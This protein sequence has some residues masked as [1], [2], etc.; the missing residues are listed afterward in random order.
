VELTAKLGGAGCLWGNGATNRT[1]RVNASGIYTVTVTNLAGC[2]STSAP[3][4]VS[5]EP[6]SLGGAAQAESSTI[7]GGNETAIQLSGQ[8]GVV[9]LWQLSSDGRSWADI[10]SSEGLASLP[11][12]ILWKETLYRAVVQSGACASVASTIA[13]VSVISP[14]AILE[15]PQSAEV[16]PEDSV[17]FTVKAEGEGLIYQWRR[18]NLILPGATKSSY[19]IRV[20]S[21]A[22]AG[23]YMVVIRNAC[24]EWVSSSP[25]FLTVSSEP[26]VIILADDVVCPGTTG[27][28]ASIPDEG[29]D[30]VYTWMIDGGIIL[31]G[32]RSPS[33]LYEV[34]DSGPVELFVTVQ[35]APGCER[36]S[37][38]LVKV[39]SEDLTFSISDV[40]V[41]EGDIGM[42]E[43]VLMVTLSAPADCVVSVRWATEDG[44]ARADED[45]FPAFGMLVFDPGE[46]TKPVEIQVIG[47]LI[48][49]LDEHF[50]V[51]LS[52][53][54]NARILKERG[55]VTI[56]DDDPMPQ[57]SIEDIALVEGDSGTTEA[58]LVITLS[59]PS[60]EEVSV[61]IFTEDGSAVAW[62]DYIPIIGREVDPDSVP[63]SRLNIA[64]LGGKLQLSWSSLFRSHELQFTETLSDES[65]WRT[66]PVS[67]FLMHDKLRV[68]LDTNGNEGFYRL[69]RKD[70]FRLVFRPGE[71]EKTISVSIIGDELIEPDEFFV[72]KLSN[73][74]NATISKGEGIVTILNDDEYNDEGRARVAMIQ[75]FPDMEIRKMQRYLAE[76]NL[77]FRL[78]EPDAVTLEMLWSYDL[79]ISNGL[80][81]R[82]DSLT[83]DLVNILHQ[84]ME[85][86]IPL[87]LIGT[88]LASSGQ[89]LSSAAQTKW[90]NMLRLKPSNARGTEERVV[91][92]N[93]SHPVT[94]GPFGSIASF[95]HLDWFDLTLST[96]SGEEVLAKAGGADVL[97]AYEDWWGGIR[98]VAQNFLVDH[99]S[100]WLAAVQREKIFKNAVWWLLQLP[101]HGSHLNLELRGAIRPGM[102]RTGELIYFDLMIQH[103]GELGAS[104][105]VLTQ[106]LPLELEFVEAIFEEGI[107][108]M[109]DQTV[110][111]QVGAM[112]HS[113]SVNITIA[114]RALS[115]GSF[116]STTTVTSNR[117]EELIWDNEQV[118]QIMVWE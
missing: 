1:I 48:S 37:S 35:N 91:I 16:C 47:D 87:Y 71:T 58:R 67:P 39:I 8:R 7:C 20:V 89:E 92:F 13:T 75:S 77:S 40:M 60:S 49:E 105:V 6:E 32:E 79:V 61:K 11:T 17:I 27:H 10:P 106:E 101:S 15:D 69:Q 41:I 102:L 115:S 74:L 88:E 84:L 25:A 86:G 53:A 114:A 23:D 28:L 93:P 50:F 72:V 70:E 19:T 33:I 66:A 36:A 81:T 110:I 24:G 29:I 83:D 30:A 57:L 96:G 38:K 78:F 104:G 3:L 90:I 44:A 2:T 64:Q 98:T 73:A 107:V 55:R 42:T 52:E 45:Y 94:H 100:S 118:H 26:S 31:S 82:S 108:E 112:E 59:S 46:V 117:S 116:L 103:S 43:A 18:G 68:E 111:W 5:A 63:E 51:V 34:L 76:M 99:G 109:E 12:G 85:W 80:G 62:E 14:P 97:V 22:D 9:L 113:K 65:V 4:I 56:L 21:E 54:S 95:K